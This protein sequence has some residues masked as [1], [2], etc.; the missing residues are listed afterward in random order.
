MPATIPD[1]LAQLD[2]VMAC[3][4][5]RLAGRLRG[6]EKANRAGRDLGPTLDFIADDIRLSAQR[7]AE[8]LARLPKPSYDAQLPIVAAKDEIAKAIAG[9]Q[10]VVLCGQTGSGKTTQLPKIC[11]ELGRGA[12][13]MIG[14]TQPR[15]IAAR[16]GAARV[17]QERGSPLGR[18]VG[19]K[20]RF[21]DVT[22][23]DA[24]VKVM[25]D[26][27]LLAETQGDRFLE[28]YDTL[29]IDEAHERSLN[30]DFLLGYLRQVLPRRRDLK[31]IITS[32]TIDPQRFAKHFSI[33]GEEVPVIEVSGRMYPVEV[34]YRPIVSGDET[35]D[36]ADEK[37]IAEKNAGEKRAGDSRRRSDDR[38]LLGAIVGAVEEVIG[39]SRSRHQL[40]DILVFLSGEREIRDAAEALRKHPATSTDTEIL[41]LYARL[42]A[43]AQQRV[44]GALPG[45]V[46]RRVVL[47]TNVAET[48]LTV[49]G[50]RYVI[51]PGLARVSRYNARYRVERLPIEAISQASAEQRKGRCGRLSEGVCVR[52]YSE[53]DFAKRDEFTQPEI[54]RSNLASVIL[55]MKALHLGDVEAFPFL[56]PPDA[57]LVKD[58]YFTLYELG[59]I[60]PA[61]PKRELTPLGR[62]LARLPIDPCLGRMILAA[63]D[64]RCVSEVLVIAAAM[65]VQDPRERPID[66]QALA[67]MAHASFRDET[68]DFLTFLRL[69][70]LYHE[71]SRA[72]SKNQ[73]RKWCQANYLS[74]TRMREWL[75]I[76]SQL[77]QIVEESLTSDNAPIAAPQDPLTLEA[78]ADRVHRSLLAGLLSSVGVKGET[79]EYTG[80]RG[81]KFHLFP[82]SSLFGSRPAWVMAG[83]LVETTRLYARTVAPVQPAWI[84]RTAAHLIERTYSEPYWD[85]NSA[86]VRAY[87]KVTLYGLTIVPKRRV[88]YGPIDPVASRDL[89]IR[90]ALVEGDYQSNAPFLL[91]NLDLVERVKTLEAKARRRDLL[92]DAAKRFA[93]YDERVPAGMHNGPVFEKWRRQA[94]AR[95]AKLLFMHP[96]MVMSP[97][98]AAVTPERYPD[99]IRIDGLTLDL[100]Y[101][102]D[103]GAPDD[104][105]TATIPLAVLNQVPAWR[106]DWLVPGMLKEKCV[107]L[108]RHL[109]KAIRVSFVGAAKFAEAAVERVKFADAPLWDSLS[110]VLGNMAGVEIPRAAWVESARSLPDHLR[111]NLRVRDEKGRQVAAGR[112]IEAIRAKFRKSAAEVFANL[113]NSP[114]HRDNVTRWDFGDLRDSVELRHEGMTLIGYPAVYDRV[115]S[116]SLRLLDTD[117]EARK[118]TRGGV[119]RLFMLHLQQEL[120][121]VAA[122]MPKEQLTRLCALYA[123]LGPSDLL[124]RHLLEAITDRV[125]LEKPAN[126]PP[127]RTAME[128]ELRIRGHWHRLHTEAAEVCAL[129]GKI[130][131]ARQRVATL[132]APEPAVLLEPA[133]DDMREQLAELVPS[134]F[135]TGTPWTWLTHVPRYLA[136][137]QKRYEKL[138]TGW[139]DRDAKL[140]S[141]ITPWLLAHRRRR[142]EHRAAGIADAQLDTFRWML[143][144]MRVSLFA[145]ELGTA[146]PVSL[147]R[148]EQQWA[149]TRAG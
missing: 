56:D 110:A 13:G 129:A 128:F 94:E 83:E 35:G 124:K 18:D 12:A 71:Q 98:G 102:Y 36:A 54:L 93:F 79:H 126:L 97:E 149:A 147:K 45:G 59:A 130:L 138:K 105:V 14:H 99:E 27:I 32:A 77:R 28:Q 66:A 6:V 43:D 20:V 68:S 76:H 55:R 49:P 46:S 5:S 22:Q 38:D 11:L 53:D 100:E 69:W 137:M 30:I 142:S 40:G 19:Y 8:R 109:P 16:N 148:L 7:R 115:S 90:S 58:G 122:L 9:H 125:F 88:H 62:R 70:S 118:V 145:Q 140:L 42:S 78:V 112:D 121:G 133:V 84:E 127:V 26:G 63:Q 123:P 24:L 136:A 75:D 44:F 61:D 33:N 89:F 4:R 2:A 87:E 57:R 120:R 113:P 144:E 101:R 132:L 74:H 81:V 37:A 107:E 60:D 34:M 86:H 1:L 80:P 10:V 52:L 39:L 25:T 50:I 17:A 103:P 119:R 146:T 51:D 106:F 116:V 114:M 21:T 73:L 3:D 95:D 104:G 64:E 141:Q 85:R 31:L 92:A 131:D 67:D 91:H 134:D 96:A 117:A 143:E 111:M 135:M 139:A 15:R 41:P 29:I 108:I 72:L 65:S 23:R 47:A 48:S 82:G